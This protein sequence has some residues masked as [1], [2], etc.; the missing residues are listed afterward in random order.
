M[1][2]PKRTEF[3]VRKERAV[4]V[5]VV[6]PGED[7]GGED[8]LDELARLAETAGAR[9]AERI[10]QKLSRIDPRTYVGK[11]KAD[12]LREVCQAVDADAII[13]DHDLSP[14]QIH[15]LEEI[16]ETKVVDRS[17]LILDIFATRAKTRQAKVQVE[18][19]QLEYTYPR[20]TRMWSHLDRHG[21]GIGT[22]GPGERQLE[23]DRRAFGRRM[24]D[25][26]RELEAIAQRKRRQVAARREEFR[27]CLVGYTNAGKSTLLNALTDADAFVE[28]RLF[29]TLDTKTRVWHLDAGREAL[30]SDTVGFI[31][32]LP[33]HLVASFHAT[34][35]EAT[36]ADL[37]LH[38]VDISHPDC[39]HQAET[40]RQVL[41]EIGCGDTPAILVFNKTD[42]AKPSS[43][44]ELLAASSADAVRVSALHGEG[45]EAL[46]RR[47]LDHV[48][49]RETR[50]T[51][52]A[53]CTNGRLL[54]SLHEFATVLGTRRSDEHMVVEARIEPRHLP[55]VRS[56]AGPQD[57]IRVHD[58]AVP[59]GREAS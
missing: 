42:V 46:R 17:E 58:A 29:A 33:H 40:V 10:T 44:A 25:L 1:A 35:E 45:L 36:E 4:L 24:R 30:L 38:V 18:L 13:C 16:T 52:H 56:A 54:A 47:V 39:L 49:R 31:R 15:T 23:S 27:V 11:G 28:D 5:A 14:G 26:R 59:S 2:E 22:R 19:A 34:L 55:A 8:I 9:V 48:A 20:L 37:L 53:H 3:S 57:T 32:R 21:G 7:H 51:V 12:E 6:L 43:E 50:V 41:E